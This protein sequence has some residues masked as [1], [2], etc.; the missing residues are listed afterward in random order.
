MS[1]LVEGVNLDLFIKRGGSLVVFALLPVSAAEGVVGVF[2]VGIDL[3]LLLE[4]GDGIV[5][6]AHAHVSGSEH[7]PGVFVFGIHFRGALKKLRRQGEIVAADGD[8][9]STRLNSN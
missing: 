5:I 4:S 1:E 2:V 8:R 6:L 3:D 9:K 7:V